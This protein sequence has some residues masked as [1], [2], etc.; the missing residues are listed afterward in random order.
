MMI[1]EQEVCSECAILHVRD[2][3]LI[4]ISSY[5]GKLSTGRYS[6]QCLGR[7]QIMYE[8]DQSPSVEYCT[9]AR[10]V[11]RTS[12]PGLVLILQSPDL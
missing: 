6:R 4:E 8:I 3:G 10:P 7:L 9:T 2:E 5:T 12:L 1:G 11:V